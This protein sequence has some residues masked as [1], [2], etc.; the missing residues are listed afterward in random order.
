MFFQ[1]FNI[2]EKS[3]TWYSFSFKET[4][5]SNLTNSEIIQDGVTGVANKNTFLNWQL[6]K[7]STRRRFSSKKTTNSKML[8]HFFLIFFQTLI[9]CSI[10]YFKLDVYKD[11]L[12]FWLLLYNILALNKIH[13]FE[14]FINKSR[15]I[16]GN[17]K[18]VEL[19]VNN[20]SL[21]SPY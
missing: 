3:D 10:Y 13:I 9:S 18:F 19:S 8:V 5:Y 2:T 21:P 12:F 16:S 4:L 11:M 7:I 15:S 17:P 6:K 20:Y 1:L 14:I